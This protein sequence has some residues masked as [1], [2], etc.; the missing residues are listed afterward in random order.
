MCT[1]YTVHGHFDQKVASQKFENL[2][3]EMLKAAKEVFSRVV[4]SKRWVWILI[5]KHYIS[6]ISIPAAK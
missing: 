4:F 5:L 2:S 6:K 3:A 1:V